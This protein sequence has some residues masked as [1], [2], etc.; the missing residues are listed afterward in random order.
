RPTKVKTLLT[1]V[2][3]GPS[4][5]GDSAVLSSQWPGSLKTMTSPRAGFQPNHGESLLT[6]TRSPIWM[7][8]CIEP[9]GMENTCTRKVWSIRVMPSATTTMIGISRSSERRLR[10]TARLAARRRSARPRV[11]RRLTPGG[12]WPYS[13]GGRLPCGLPLLPTR[14]ALPQPHLQRRE[15]GG[16]GQVPPAAQ[17][18]HDPVDPSDHPADRNESAPRVSEVGAGVRRL[19]PVVPQHEQCAF[20]D[21]DGEGESRRGVTGVEVRALVQRHAVHG[22]PPLPV[23]ADDGVPADADDPFDEGLVA[24]AEGVLAVED[25][26]VAPV[27]GSRLVRDLVDHDAVAGPQHGLHGARGHAHRLGHE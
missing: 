6:T 13:S 24:L 2:S 18:Q 1:V 23:A 11:A 15:D 25:D 3:T 8:F 27:D 14:D 4:F 16:P 19:A 26:D 10:R 9:D 5:C 20:R 17:R 12:G 21:P 22:D 7:V